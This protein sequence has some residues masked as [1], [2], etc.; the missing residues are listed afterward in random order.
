MERLGNK[1]CTFKHNVGYS[2]ANI[3]GRVKTQLLSQKSII[4]RL[5]SSDWGS[6]RV[7]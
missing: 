7:F 2:K 1:L 5:S 3:I 4:S 6:N